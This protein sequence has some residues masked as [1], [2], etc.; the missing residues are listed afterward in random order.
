MIRKFARKEVYVI[1]ALLFVAVTPLIL[2]KGE[3]FDP[4]DAD[5]R[6]II[7]TPHNETI[8]REFGEAFSE[9]WKEKTG[10]VVYMDWRTPG[11]TSEIRLILDGEFSRADERG[12]EGIGVDVLFG[13]GDYIF[14]KMASK[15]RLQKLDVF[16]K[17]KQWFGGEKGIRQ[18]FTGEDCYGQDHQ[19]VGVCLSRFGICYNMD[20]LKRLG[21]KPPESWDDLGNPRYFGHIALADPTKSGSVAKAFEMLVQQKIHKELETISRE[22]G[23]SHEHMIDR[24]KS[25]G[26]TKGFQL[27]QKISANARYFTDSASKIPHDVAQGDAVAGMCVDFYGR[28]YNEKLKKPDGSSRLQWVTPVG[29]TST[30]VDPVAVLRGA[31]HPKLAQAFVEF[32]LTEKGQL[33]WNN[34][35]GT[36]NGPKHHAIRRLPVRPDLYTPD[37]LQF[38]TD[39]E[40]MPYEGE[41]DFVYNPELTGELFNAM[42]NAIKVMCIDTHDELTD[43]WET[44]IKHSDENGVMPPMALQNFSEVRLFSYKKTY[45]LK[46]ILNERSSKKET[47]RVL[48][49]LNRLAAIF[50]RSYADSQKLA[51]QNK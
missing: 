26:W 51:K 32:L 45:E 24:A 29:G 1:L 37:R 40:I 47:L 12:D 10:E 20:G 46:K 42:R 4:D 16:E 14:K 21:L 41:P 5:T 38:F 43:A 30:S 50:R 22:P 6:L 9:Y 36:P 33:L 19:W 48:D 49:K 23:E 25:Q 34:K 8:R 15:G 35:P 44:L 39:P 13:G 2:Q 11:G 7:M 3:P 18:N 28:A 27:I 31:E 17:Q